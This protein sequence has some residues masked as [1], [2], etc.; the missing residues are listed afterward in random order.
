M[1]GAGGDDGLSGGSDDDNLDGGDGV[2]T[3][4]GGD[5]SDT[6]INPTPDEGATNCELPPP[7]P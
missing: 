5:G 7:T 3:N 4:D 6:C 1:T 2:N